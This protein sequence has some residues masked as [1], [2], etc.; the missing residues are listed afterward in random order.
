MREERNANT[1]VVGIPEWKR[2]LGRPK[3]RWE[4]V[5]QVACTRI[6]WKSV[7]CIQLT[8]DREHL[9]NL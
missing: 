8:Q 3:H 7:D 1:V 6:G 4:N 5:I 9:M 2:P